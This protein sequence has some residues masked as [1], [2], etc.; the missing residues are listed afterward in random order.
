MAGMGSYMNINHKF[1]K[2]KQTN[3]HLLNPT[4]IHPVLRFTDPLKTHTYPLP[5]IVLEILF[6][7]LSQGNHNYT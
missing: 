5:Q 6:L 7:C 3:K 2:N 4:I 1:A